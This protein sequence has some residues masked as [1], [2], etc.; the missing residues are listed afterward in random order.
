MKV[1]Q[2]RDVLKRLRRRLPNGILIIRTRFAI[3]IGIAIAIDGLL[4]GPGF[5]SDSDSDIDSEGAESHTK[6]ASA[7][8]V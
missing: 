2:C 6:S 4:G 7:I 8:V 3:A 5:D 1:A